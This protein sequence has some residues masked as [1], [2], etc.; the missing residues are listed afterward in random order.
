MQKKVLLILSFLRNTPKSVDEAIA[1]AK[2]LNAELVAFFIL[3]IEFAE[4]IVHKL[5]DEGWIGGQPS[6]QLYRS[7]LR[8]YKLQSQ[9][10]LSEIEKRAMKENVPVRTLVRSGNLLQETLKLN[11]EEKPD[12]IVISRRR[13]SKLSRL[14]LGSL[15]SALK[16][17]VSCDVR[18]IEAD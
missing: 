8:E 18:I 17:K 4:K 12:M 15:V 5:T 14:I 3:D 9:E 7:L 13:R 6:E 11:A 10:R 1:L 16:E 2:E